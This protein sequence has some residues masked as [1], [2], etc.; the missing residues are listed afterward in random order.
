MTDGA[1][2]LEVNGEEVLLVEEAPLLIALGDDHLLNMRTPGGDEDLA[3]GFLLGEGVVR[4]KDQV[5]SITLHRKGEP[6][7]LP[8][9]PPEVD[10]VAIEL[11]ESARALGKGRLSRAHEIRPSCG[12]C[13]AA[14]AEGLTRGLA[15]LA[16]GTPRTSLEALLAM[17]DLMRARQ[18]L[19]Q[20]TGGSHAAAL[21]RAATGELWAL[22][23]DVGRHNAVDK[24]IGRAARDGR[25][26]GEAA[27]VLSGRGGF[28]LV[29][30]ALRVGIPV[31]A[32]VS[33][34]TSLAVEIAEEAGATLVGFLRREGTP[35][36][37][38]DDGRL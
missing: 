20:E 13:G 27:L 3:L 8:G 36:V 32:S 19:F 10:V 26:L 37:Y 17:G 38:T 29:L 23:E 15:S 2:R 24:A 9:P 18:A 4:S 16:P 30:K 31:I 28:E 6:S 14:T 21:F 12:V 33:A 11:D 25:P 35:R 5:R 7:P 1:R 34:P 22:G